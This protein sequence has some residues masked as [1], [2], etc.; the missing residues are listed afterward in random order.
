MSVSSHGSTC[1]SKGH[2][3]TD[4]HI[5]KNSGF[6]ALWTDA[7]FHSVVSH[8][9]TQIVFRRNAAIHVWFKKP[10][11]KMATHEQQEG[12]LVGGNTRRTL[13][14]DVR[15]P[16]GPKGNALTETTLAWP[17]PL[18]CGFRCGNQN[19]VL[20]HPATPVEPLR[21]RLSERLHPDSSP[22]FGTTAC[23]GDTPDS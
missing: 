17:Q 16:G 10:L 11:E 20:T 14:S 15:L 23:D 13:T 6:V 8:Q 2:L 21:I 5:L 4:P 18:I 22:R 3:F 7:V 1:D 12:S 9:G 19:S